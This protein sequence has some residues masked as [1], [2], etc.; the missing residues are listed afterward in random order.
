MDGGV[1]GGGILLVALAL[2][3]VVVLVP[4][5]A[6]R[7]QQRV[8]AQH[9]A[10]IQRT[11]RL[12]AET[13]ELPE[14]HVL[15]ANAKEAFKQQ[16]LLKEARERQAVL[17]RLEREKRRA[18]ARLAEYEHK[19]E[20]AMHRAALRRAK[21][22]HPR[23]KPVRIIAA[24]A[25][26]LGALGVL[27]GA[28]MAI[29]GLGLFTLGASGA[30]L[31]LGLG[32]LIALAPGKAPRAPQARVATTPAAPVSKPEL[33]DFVSADEKAT[34]EAARAAYV[35]QQ[36]KAARER[37]RARAMAR[38]RA[39]RAQTPEQVNQTNSILLRE[40]TPAPATPASVAGDTQPEATPRDATQSSA[41]PSTAQQASAQPTKPQLDVQE[42]SRRLR[43][44]ARLRA[45]GVVGDTSEGAPD[46]AEALRRRRNAS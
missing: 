21:L 38:A 15:E 13:A 30:A 43:A 29:G 45:M 28:G 34:A 37:E 20:V 23:L 10:R 1:L 19:K 41:Q 3:W 5:W 9:A 6:H 11:V 27:V 8:A 39:Q 16:K 22:S 18:E 24:L 44:E 33:V 4:S 32:T 2:L 42:Q 26:V 25:A 36:E 7:R 14:E 40:A 31:A 35:A 12:L 46:L 17:D